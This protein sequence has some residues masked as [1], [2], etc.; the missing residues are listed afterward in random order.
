MVIY[1]KYGKH[2]ELEAFSINFYRQF[3]LQIMGFR[4]YLTNFIELNSERLR[5]HA[6]LSQVVVY[7]HW[8]L[9]LRIQSSHNFL[10]VR[11]SEASW[12][13]LPSIYGHLHL[14]QS[15][16]KAAQGTLRQG[17]S[18]VG[19]GT[20]SLLPSR[21]RR[22]RFCRIGWRFCSP[23]LTVVPWSSNSILSCDD[24]FHSHH[25]H[26]LN[27]VWDRVQELLLLALYCFYQID[28][29]CYHRLS[30]QPTCFL[31]QIMVVYSSLSWLLQ[32]LW[33]GCLAP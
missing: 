23:H 5:H 16:W 28:N 15:H 1:R 3:Y 7:T 22:L 19:L 2:A 10:Q 6:H 14:C 31:L 20:S 13:F 33:V 21:V 24:E 18:P 26:F 17:C 25:L 32:R 11:D 29:S 9:D 8:R 27:W 4:A 30:F 12:P